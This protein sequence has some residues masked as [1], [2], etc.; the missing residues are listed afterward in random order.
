MMPRAT[1]T[2]YSPVNSRPIRTGQ[3]WKPPGSFH[4]RGP[5][6]LISSGSFQFSA[7]DLSKVSISICFLIRFRGDPEKGQVPGLQA[8]EWHHGRYRSIPGSEKRRLR[9]SAGSSGGS[10][11]A[12]SLCLRHFLNGYHQRARLS[13]QEVLLIV[14]NRMGFKLLLLL[15]TNRGSVFRVQYFSGYFHP[16]CTES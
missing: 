6:D 8:S 10:V 2:G 3:Y 15:K 14:Q 4:G 12:R 9:I 16:S 5:T 11:S 7:E 13:G 1:V